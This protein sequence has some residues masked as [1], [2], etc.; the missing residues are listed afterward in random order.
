MADRIEAA[1]VEDLADGDIKF[2]DADR[3][4][5]LI[6]L[7]TDFYAIDDECTHSA[8]SLSDGF[9]DGEVL[10]CGCHGSMF[11]VKT[12]EVQE[13]PAEEPV[14][15]YQVEVEDDTVYVIPA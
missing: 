14:P 9:L 4:V 3:P 8:C 7:G 12:G 1:K 11:N 13:G 15:T 6:R 5:V 2:V 10:E